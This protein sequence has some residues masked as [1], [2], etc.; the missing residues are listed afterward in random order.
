VVIEKRS[1]ILNFKAR[2]PADAIDPTEVAR[3]ADL[4]QQAYGDDALERA[5]RIESQAK[6]PQFAAAVTAEI[7]RRLRKSQA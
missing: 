1:A 2:K 4:L 3:A 7:E 6:S 5:R